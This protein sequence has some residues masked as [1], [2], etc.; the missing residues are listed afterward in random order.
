MARRSTMTGNFS[1]SSMG[2]EKHART[3]WQRF[4]LLDS[5]NIIEDPQSVAGTVTENATS[6]SFTFAQHTATSDK[7]PILGYVAAKPLRDSEGRLLT[8]ADC[9][10]LRVRIELITMSGDFTSSTSGTTKNKPEVLFGICQNSSDFDSD[11]NKHLSVGWRNRADSNQSETI[12]EAPVLLKCSLQT[13]GTGQ[14]VTTV[15]SGIGDGTKIIEAQI[16]VGPDLDKNGNNSQMISQVYGPASEDFLLASDGSNG[17][18]NTDLN[19]N[20]G[21]FGSGQIYLFFAV[22][23]CNSTNSS[24]SL[25]TFQW[26]ASY[27]IE[28]STFQDGGYGTS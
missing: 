9:F 26:R 21:N 15:T 22:S 2:R 20:Q 18:G 8:F 1:H 13:D 6:T 16:C 23:D 28:A 7:S 5:D 10:S 11:T 17:F 24:S 25:C 12:D 4:R 3:G 27:M 19:L 14:I